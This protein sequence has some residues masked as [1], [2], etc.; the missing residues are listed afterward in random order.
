LACTP[1]AVGE[2]LALPYRATVVGASAPIF[3]GAGAQYYATAELPVGSQV[4]VYEHTSMEF[5]AIRP[6]QGSFS[7]LPASAVELVEEGVGQV[8]RDGAPARVGSLMH[9]RRD[10]VHVRLDEGE[11]VRVLVET[12]VEGVAWLQIAPPA[13]EFR[14]IERSRISTTIGA[15]PLEAVEP[16]E[17]GWVV[18]TAHE[19]QPKPYP[20]TGDQAPTAAVTGAAPLAGENPQAMVWLPTPSPAAGAAPAASPLTG[21]FHQYLSALEIALSRQVAELPTMWRLEPIEQQAAGLLAAAQTEAERAA[22]RDFA[23]R[24]DRF[25]SI[26]NRYKATRGLAPPVALTKTAIPLPGA[27]GVTPLD[28]SVEGASN[29]DAVGVLRPVVSKRPNAPQFALVDDEGKIVSFV[30]ARPDLNLSPLVGKR[31]GVQG[32]KGFMP[33][34]QHEHLTAGRVT[35]LLR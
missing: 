15:T 1:W 19:D 18:A 31:V 17:S 23:S 30:T 33:E 3:S 10:V 9:A 22:V 12:E 32:S 24:V 8:K 35:P 27:P 21:S 6:P 7:W 25:A 4:E 5:C 34:Y 28:A 13:G 14:W 20:T 26:A 2:E 16:N 11:R 29:Y